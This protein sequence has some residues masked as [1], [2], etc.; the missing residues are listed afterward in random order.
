M[1]DY[2]VVLV[3]EALVL[4]VDR[5]LGEQKAVVEYNLM[6][7]RLKRYPMNRKSVAATWEAVM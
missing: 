6:E 2:I 1:L 5:S 4:A 7:E 3:E